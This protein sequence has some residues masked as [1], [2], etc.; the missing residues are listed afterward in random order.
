ME[1]HSKEKKVKALERGQIRIKKGSI[2]IYIQR[3]CSGLLDTHGGVQSGG[4]LCLQQLDLLFL[5]VLDNTLFL[6]VPDLRMSAHSCNL[7][8][9]T[10]PA[11]DAV[12]V[13]GCV[14]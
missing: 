2:T 12:L 14:L 10:Y 1:S 4:A 7:E 6:K 13:E 9:Y 3:I 11:L 8:T 5:L